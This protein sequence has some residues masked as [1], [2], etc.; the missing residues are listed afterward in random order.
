MVINIRLAT[1][2]TPVSN[3]SQHFCFHN[4]ILDVNPCWHRVPL[5]AVTNFKWCLQLWWMLESLWYFVVTRLQ[6][7]LKVK[8]IAPCDYVVHPWTEMFQTIPS[9]QQMLGCHGPTVHPWVRIVSYSKE[10]TLT[11]HLD[12]DL[13]VWQ[14]CQKWCVFAQAAATAL[15]KLMCFCT[16]SWLCTLMSVR[17]RERECFELNITNAWDLSTQQLLQIILFCIKHADFLCTIIGTPIS[18]T[19]LIKSEKDMVMVTS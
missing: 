7:S 10:Q 15:S 6:I 14:L 2:N 3:A 13:V 9:M 8:G 17:E 11:V 18:D 19:S 12:C 4:A 1:K 5:T 16:G